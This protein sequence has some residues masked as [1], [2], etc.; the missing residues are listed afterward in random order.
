MT[1]CNFDEFVAAA[2]KG[3]DKEGARHGA[4]N[5]C[6][7]IKIDSFISKFCKMPWES[8]DGLADSSVATLLNAKGLN[9]PLELKMQLLLNSEKRP[10]LFDLY[11]DKLQFTDMPIDI[12]LRHFLQS[13][14]LPRAPE[15]VEKVLLAFS[16]RYKDTNPACLISVE[17]VYLLAFHTILL[18]TR[19]HNIGVKLKI[20]MEEF[21]TC[22]QGTAAA[23]CDYLGSFECDVP[24]LVH[25]SCCLR[26]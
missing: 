10:K 19:N 11:M 6:Q 18:L 24:V 12:A 5:L 25:A 23:S 21:I 15:K 1:D 8:V 16:K 3:D 2:M 22:M 20:T 26:F 7:K 17:G 9:L 13:H 14:L 4:W